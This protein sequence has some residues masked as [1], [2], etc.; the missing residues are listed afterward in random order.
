M[1][2][3]GGGV[4]AAI[5]V[6]LVVGRGT[7]WG[8]DAQSAR[9]EVQKPSAE[10]PGPDGAA[11]T[12]PAAGQQ[13]ML[14]PYGRVG[15][16]YTLGMM[17][18]AVGLG[19]VSPTALYDPANGYFYY[20][21]VQPGMVTITIGSPDGPQT[22]YYLS[23]GPSGPMPMQYYAALADRLR[24]LT[25]ETGM[26]RAQPE[27]SSPR[28]AEREPQAPARRA[29]G[30][31][32]SR[33]SAMLGGPREVQLAF[34]LGEAKLQEG[35]FPEAVAAF[36]RAA[37]TAPRTAAPRL[38]LSL[39]L[40]GEGQYDPAAD[41]LTTGLSLVSDLSAIRLDAAAAFG[42][43]ETYQAVETRLATVARGDPAN[44]DLQLLLGFGYFATGRA[45]EAAKLLQAAATANPDDSAIKGLLEAARA[46]VGGEAAPAVKPTA[47]RQ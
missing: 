9:P 19:A 10:A 13:L 8:A 1:R 39:A 32:G 41:E 25:P 36:R 16:G 46:R 15:S 12:A 22:T 34:A 44:K 30:D 6:V 23:A 28:A 11:P 40:L 45:A 38:A 20:P 3:I 47:E 33:L 5:A 24:S 17:Q 43:A 37:A 27:A 14:D 35:R 42:G 18:S 7:A 21:G 31:Y 29:G 26:A 4:A 2:L